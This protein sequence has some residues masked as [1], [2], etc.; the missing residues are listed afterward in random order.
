MFVDADSQ[1]SSGAAAGPSK[2][3]REKDEEAEAILKE[4]LQR[5]NMTAVKEDKAE[6][7]SGRS[8]GGEWKRDARSLRSVF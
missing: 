3:K 4:V 6:K 5:E 7:C 1:S 8:S 2:Q